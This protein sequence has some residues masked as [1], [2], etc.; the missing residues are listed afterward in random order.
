MQDQRS[1]AANTEGTA[2][3]NTNY[4]VKYLMIRACRPEENARFL[5]TLI[6]FDNPRSTEPTLETP[7]LFYDTDRRFAVDANFKCLVSSKEQPPML[8]CTPQPRT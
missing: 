6:E 3:H 1:D 2:H 4:L 5:E 7:T 8:S